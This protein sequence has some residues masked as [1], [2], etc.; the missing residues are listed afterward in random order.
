[1]ARDKLKD[2][3]RA[4]PYGSSN[5]T[6]EIQYIID[7]QGDD[8]ADPYVDDLKDDLKKALGDYASFETKENKYR[9]KDGMNHFKL[10]GDD[11]KA[12]AYNSGDGGAENAFFQ[13]DSKE[14]T[15][16][17]LRAYFD[18]ISGGSTPDAKGGGTFDPNQ[19]N[20]VLDKSGKDDTKSGD[21]TLR[22]ARNK[23]LISPVLTQF[24]RFHP[25]G[26]SPY[27]ASGDPMTSGQVD[28][29]PF[30]SKQNELG[31]YDNSS[32]NVKLKEMKD[33]GHKLVVAATGHN[34]TTGDFLA[35][36]LPSLQQLGASKTDPND[37]L[38]KN[39]ESPGFGGGNKDTKG[40]NVTK[41]YDGYR[42]KSF[43]T[44]NSPLEPFG[45]T[46][47]LGMTTLVIALVLAVGILVD[48]V[49]MI[50]GS[51]ILPLPSD[52]K[53]RS[54]YNRP[55]PGKIGK[56]FRGSGAALVKPSFFGVRPTNMDFVEA[57]SLGSEIFFG[58]VDAFQGSSGG[59]FSFLPGG[60]NINDSPGYYAIVFRAVIRSTI[61]IGLA[62]GDIFKGGLFAA[63]GAIADLFDTIR[64]SKLVGYMNM[65]AAL[66]DIYE[67]I[68]AEAE[69]NNIIQKPD[70]A[71][72]V[73]DTFV[74][75]LDAEVIE[76]GSQH[77]RVGK[78]K[79]KPGDTT[80]VWRG[81]A[82]PSTYLIAGTAN[83][84]GGSTGDAAF[85]LGLDDFHYQVENSEFL[86]EDHK[87]KQQTPEDGS[88]RLSAAL[89]KKVE[90][91]SEGEYMPFYFHDLRTNE[92]TGFHAFLTSLSD[93]YTAN[94]DSNQGY[95]RADPVMIYNN[96][97]RSIGMTFWIVATD[98]RDFDE[99]WWKINKLTTLLYPQYSAGTQVVNPDLNDGNPF[100]AP[101]SQVIAASPM[102]RLR[103]GDLFK[104]N[105]SKFGL[106]RIFGVDLQKEVFENP[107]TNAEL[108]AAIE[109]LE[110][111]GASAA[112]G[113]LI[114]SYAEPPLFG[115][116][117][118][119]LTNKREARVLMGKSGKKNKLRSV[120]VPSGM[121]FEIKSVEATVESIKKFL[122]SGNLSALTT[123]GVAAVKIS[124]PPEP[125]IDKDAPIASRAARAQHKL[126]YNTFMKMIKKRKLDGDVLIPYDYLVNPLIFAPDPD[127][128]D[129]ALA[130]KK[131]QDIKETV[132]TFLSAD[133]NPVA[134]AFESSMGRGLAGFITQMDFQWL[135][136]ITW[137]VEEGSK[138]PKAC[139]VT[140]SFSP[141]HDIGPGLAHDGMNR[142]PIYGVG[143]AAGKFAGGPYKSSKVD[144]S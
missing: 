125:E 107:T 59:L 44:L 137:E 81:R 111:V 93:S 65:L 106:A 108:K 83:T 114:P 120:N 109:A 15:S 36:L 86:G 131:G 144:E 136:Q 140:I 42:A 19:I 112:D 49:A 43:G 16:E 142:A 26:K 34:P 23:K 53:I 92:I 105:Y 7:H 141:V 35:G 98:S 47:K 99:M 104:S 30:V 29:L 8:T 37:M 61:E 143:N 28:S 94:Y 2:F 4:S 82:A 87:L 133:T 13:Q 73:I 138:A 85:S 25:D 123:Y 128:L 122:N 69:N 91:L 130:D 129:E 76:A 124:P 54:G 63:L 127:S 50:I 38:A 31:E 90:D 75:T 126:K 46:P 62:F 96:T 10:T 48:L 60:R 56:H 58:E 14:L 121:T 11:G 9:L 41:V 40:A 1:M 72:G 84:L 103:L 33:I 5:G 39:V 89:V 51:L 57:T 110:P 24:N 79:H 70:D 67:D 78:S 32:A 88:N 27:N 101:F 135:D 55:E 102:I 64:N 3:L 139:Q 97:Q 119:K 20:D 74:S 118:L 113:P 132:N 116:P 100:V 117:G 66:G 21:T 134:R 115:T 95:G 6:E 45:A 71:T 22:D 52:A 77:L 17:D 68:L 18:T 12:A 80:L